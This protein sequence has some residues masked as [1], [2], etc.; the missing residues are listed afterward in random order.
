MPL[1]FDFELFKIQC[2][3]VPMLFDALV[4]SKF[5]LHGWPQRQHNS[6]YH[7]KGTSRLT[8]LNMDQ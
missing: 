6:V 7:I 3:Q 1:L 8:D 4:Y 5:V 2:V